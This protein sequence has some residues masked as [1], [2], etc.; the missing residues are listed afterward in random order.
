MIHAMRGVAIVIGVVSLSTVLVGCG[1]SDPV[2]S[3]PA[4]ALTLPGEAGHV[5]GIVQARAGGLL[6]G[7]HGGLF[8]QA[9]D[10]TLGRVG[11]PAD[12][13]G[14]AALPSGALL[15]SG[16]PAPGSDEPDPLGLR[17]SRD[18]GRSW[19]TITQVPRDDFHVIEAGGGRIYAVGSDRAVYAGDAPTTLAKVANAPE[20]LVDLAVEPGRGSSLLASTQSGLLRSTNGGRTWMPAGEAVGLLAWPRTDLVFLVDADGVV[21]AS[22]DRGATWSRRGEIGAPPAALMA[23]SPT[24]LVAADHD[25]RI[26][27][28]R[29]GGGTWSQ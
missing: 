11:D 24:N 5:H 28:S 9:P 22:A 2:A 12:Y 8:A 6:V 14:L 16:H 1:S 17:V 25:D 26:T 21:S 27:T 29:D 10:G 3:Q 19:T 15:S 18:E 7:T 20:G 23:T 4:G 13:M